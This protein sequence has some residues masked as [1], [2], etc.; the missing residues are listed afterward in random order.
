MY[1]K[2]YVITC[3]QFPN[4]MIGKGGINCIKIQKLKK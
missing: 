1:M 4:P 3:N 2:L